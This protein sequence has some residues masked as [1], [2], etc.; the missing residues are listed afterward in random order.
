MLFLRDTISISEA[1]S[2]LYSSTNDQKGG[3]KNHL[4]WSFPQDIV[5]EK[6]L[7]GREDPA[8]TRRCYVEEVILRGAFSCVEENLDYPARM[9]KKKLEKED[10]VGTS[11]KEDMLRHG[12]FLRV[13]EDC[14]RG[15]E[16]TRQEDAAV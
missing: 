7:R 15:V 13:Q 10:P 3:E 4:F 5:E 2:L 14:G 11:T 9:K 8:W 16:E 6:I 1:Y 12:T